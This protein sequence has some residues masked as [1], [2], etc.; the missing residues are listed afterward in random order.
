MRV[1]SLSQRAEKK[2]CFLAILLMAAFTCTSVVFPHMGKAQAAGDSLATAEVERQFQEG[3]K[4]YRYGDYGRAA[5]HL[6]TVFQVTPTMRYGGE[7]GEEQVDYAGTSAYWLGQAYTAQDRSRL[8]RTIWAAGVQQG[9]ENDVFDIRSADAYIRSVFRDS[10]WSKYEPASSTYL[11]LLEASDREGAAQRK[12]IRRHVA[13]AQFLLPQ[14]KRQ[15]LLDADEKAVLDTLQQAGGKLAAWWRR[16]DPKPATQL[17]ERVIEHLRRVTYAETHYSHEESPSGFDDRGRIYVRLGPPT[18]STQ[19]DFNSSE[20]L[21]V[22][23]R[24]RQSSGN[25][26][27]V[28]SSSFAENEYWVYERGRK[29]Y[30]YLFVDNGKGY[31]IGGVSDIIPQHLTGALDKNTGRGGAKTDVVLEALRTAYRQLSLYRM[32]YGSHYDQLANYLGRLEEK[33]TR[34]RVESGGEFLT[35]SRRS[36]NSALMQ[37][38]STLPMDRPPDLEARESIISARKT[39]AKMADE[40]DKRVPNQETRTMNDEGSLPVAVRIARFLEDDGTTST[41]VYWG[42]SGH[43]LEERYTN[44][45]SHLVNA[46]IRHMAPDYRVRQQGQKKFMMKIPRDKDDLIAADKQLKVGGDTAMYHLALQWD[47]YTVGQ[48]GRDS[49]RA[50]QR[51]RTGVVKADSLQPLTASP[52]QLEMSDL[53][54]VLHPSGKTSSMPKRAVKQPYPFTRISEDTPLAL[55]FELYHLRMGE[56]DRTRY[57]VEYKVHRRTKQGGLE[58]LLRGAEEQRTAVS[59]SRIGGDRTR[60]EYIL[61]NS[62]DWNIEKETKLTVTVRVTDGESGQKVD[63][64]VQFLMVPSGAG[65]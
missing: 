4:A 2:C 29:P 60:K 49:I 61:L 25:N 52:K 42:L 27:I 13:Q 28:S 16:M 64:T 34:Q 7:F 3:M 10:V 65:S 46:T 48:G 63:R 26:L 21:S 47:Q 57:T 55:Y 17:N 54:P 19:V 24:I 14:D 12:T 43:N 40:R 23:R 38:S 59:T 45:K 30:S 37:S 1:F 33:R 36:D 31:R 32:E 22:I 50:G 39:E 9:I 20:L 58:R 44:S 53:V 18:T 11:L 41:R 6:R 62:D 8:A 35:Q 51:L 15:K 5:R 56:N